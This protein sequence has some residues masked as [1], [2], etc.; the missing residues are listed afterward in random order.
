MRLPSM[1]ETRFC[2]YY[3]EIA[4][5]F[6]RAQEM[7]RLSMKSGWDGAHLECLALTGRYNME[8]VSSNLFHCV[9]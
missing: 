8:E 9:V 5:L 7:S 3:L 2:Y 1:D 6:E 4:P